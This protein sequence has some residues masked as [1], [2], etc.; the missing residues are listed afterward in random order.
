MIVV[1]V[2]LKYFVNHINDAHQYDLCVLS[3]LFLWQYS[4]LQLQAANQFF[5]HPVSED[6]N[7]SAVTYMF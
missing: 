1:L 4:N 6:D 5:V 2:Y 3:F 7:K